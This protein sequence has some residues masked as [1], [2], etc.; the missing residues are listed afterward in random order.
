MYDRSG[1]G[2]F[3]GLGNNS[4]Y[5]NQTTFIDSQMRLEATAAR[6]FSHELQLAYTARADSVEIEQSALNSLPPITLRYPSLM[7]IGDVSELQQR[8]VLSFDTRDSVVVPRSGQ[9]LVAF[10][11]LSTRALGSSDAYTFVGVDATFFRPAGP[12]LTLV[13]HVALRYMPTFADAPFWALSSL[14]GDRSIIAEEQPLRAFGTGR[15]VDR[16]SFTG[17]LEARTWVQRFHVFGTDLKL[18]IAPFIDSGKVFASMSGSLLTQLHFGAGMGFRVVASPFVVGYLDIGYGAEKV[19][20]F[21]GIDY[22]F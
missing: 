15:F 5:S 9:R 22:P 13:A 16:N 4:L 11:G 6:N 12:D 3:F 21:S 10:A 19:A 17:S 2:R 7:G 8:L 14:G 1:T 18:E 20:V